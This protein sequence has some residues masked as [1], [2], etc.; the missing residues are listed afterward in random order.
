MKLWSE[1]DGDMHVDCWSFFDCLSDR[2]LLPFLSCPKMTSTTHMGLN[3]SY[4]YLP[5]MT[6]LHKVVSLQSFHCIWNDKHIISSLIHIFS[7]SIKKIT[8]H[9]T[10]PLLRGFIS[11]F[12]PVLLF[13]LTP[14][15]N[16]TPFMTERLT[17]HAVLQT[18]LCHVSFKLTNFKFHT[19]LSQFYIQ[20]TFYKHGWPI[21]IHVLADVRTQLPYRDFTRF[22]SI[23]L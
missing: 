10:H 11:A 15:V 3:G 19:G 21:S 1:T 9:R 13:V 20:S 8:R 22:F 14:I 18:M 7:N 2:R 5:L 6:C 17:D 4:F 23:C 16:H 12:R